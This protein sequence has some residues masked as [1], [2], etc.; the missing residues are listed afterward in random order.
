L[1]T[2]F[3]PLRADGVNLPTLRGV[4]TTGDEATFWVE[5]DGAAT[6]REKEG[7][8]RLFITT[9]RCRTG[10]ERYAWLKRH[11]RIARGILKA[12]GVRGDRPSPT[13]HLRWPPRQSTG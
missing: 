10:D 13:P 9:C 6:L 2:N 5:P 7:Q 12:G 4:L 8:A 11:L 3:A 1:L